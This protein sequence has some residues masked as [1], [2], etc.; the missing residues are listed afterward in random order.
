M[1]GVGE[2]VDSSLITGWMDII[3]VYGGVDVM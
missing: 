2:W 3:G 1:G